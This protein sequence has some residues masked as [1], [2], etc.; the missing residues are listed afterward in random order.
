MQTKSFNIIAIALAGVFLWLLIAVSDVLAPFILAAVLAYVTAPLA[1]QI[2][3]KFS[4]TAA[5]I[6]V[7]LLITG[8]L[9]A[10]PSALVPII[11]H[12]VA[13]LL[14]VL[15]KIIERA[16][17]FWGFTAPTAPTVTAYLKTIDIQALVKQAA[18]SVPASTAAITGKFF[19]FFG[20]GLS[21]LAEFLTF[22]LV[23]PLV[24]FYLLRDRHIIAGELIEMLPPRWRNEVLTVIG[25]LDNVLG[26]F[27]H[28]QLTV[29]I[30][31]ATIYSVALW[32][33]D[34]NFALTIGFLT[35]MLVFIP[36]VGFIIGAL[37]ATLI[38]IG[39]F[40]AWSNIAIVWA[41]MAVCTT[42]ESFFIT[43]WLVGERIGMHPA[44]VL[45]ALFIMGSLLGFTGVL[46]ALPLA[47]I[48]L[49]LLR[50]LR[51]KYINSSFYESRS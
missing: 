14:D 27:L 28:G 34:L 49:V 24:V 30:L 22:I 18:G 47:A 39:Q 9:I 4:S 45:L 7:V 11:S 3:I 8:L 13:S 19:Q 31:M 37:L 1:A 2:E 38:A 5:A 42:I 50:Y 10:L 21:A 41:L 35:G 48:V 29:M 23:T 40:D 17:S 46:V 36:Y 16:E 51:R 43:P 44:F 6:I 32:L 25:D 12:Q 20:K 26:E 33:A 15:P